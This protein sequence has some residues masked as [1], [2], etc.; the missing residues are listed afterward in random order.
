[1]PVS[2]NEILNT[3]DQ[4][5]VNAAFTKIDTYL[6]NSQWVEDMAYGGT[7][8]PHW[9]IPIFG[10]R[11]EATYNALR[12]AYLAAGWGHVTVQ[13]SSSNG[14]RAGLTMVTLYKNGHSVI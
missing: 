10:E 5:W 12:D 4:K 7:T 9:K 2:P 8:N 6:Y 14:E 13:S 11:N 3:V 1:M